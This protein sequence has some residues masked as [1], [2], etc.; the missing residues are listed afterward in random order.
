M[1]W[2][3][4]QGLMGALRAARA[5]IASKP[6]VLYM[7]SVFSP[8]DSLTPL[9]A[10]RCGLFRNTVAVVAPRGEFGTGALALKSTKKR[11]TLRMCRTLG[12]HRGLIWHASTDL[13]AE[14]IRRTIPMDDGR[15]Q[16]VVAE[17]ESELPAEPRPPREPHDGPTRFI[18][19]SR[20]TPKKGLHI[21]LESLSSVSTPVHLTIHGTTDSSTYL[22]RC[23][24][25]SRLAE[26]QGH[27][28]LFGGAVK[29]E[30]VASTFERFDYFPF[31]TA[32]ENFGHVI[33]ESLFSACPPVLPATTPW[34]ETVRQGG[35]FIVPSLESAEWSS[36][37]QNLATQ[38]P[39]E[40]ARGSRLAADA[41]R[42]WRGD[43]GDSTIF[44]VLFA[45]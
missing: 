12:I 10:R 30:D 22:A 33:S 4:R 1:V 9:I 27:E 32:N 7:N 14:E 28:I 24:E 29:P 8:W 41:F 16:V 5:A 26:R 43:R 21:L 31:P 45:P 42:T 37:L 40:R 23:K 18:F 34:T 39:Q 19:L 11:L 38:T 25:L 2:Y 17:N 6:D 44:D 36:I 13:E 35:G 20:I 15:S 3:R